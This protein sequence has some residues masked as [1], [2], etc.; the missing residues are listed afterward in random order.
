LRAPLIRDKDDTQAL[1][2]EA[3]SRVIW[4]VNGCGRVPND[5]EEK[6]AQF[7]NSE[8]VSTCTESKPA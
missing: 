6:M 2:Q 7:P 5:F 1:L 3:A 8:L 4:L